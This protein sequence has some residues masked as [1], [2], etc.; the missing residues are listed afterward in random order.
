MSPLSKLRSLLV[1]YELDAYLIT[2]C[3][4]FSSYKEAPLQLLM[5]FSG[6]NGFAIIT[7]QIALLC[8]DGRYLLQAKHELNP[9][10]SIFDLYSPTLPEDIQNAI[11]SQST[12]SMCTIGYNPKLVTQDFLQNT[13]ITR[14]ATANIMWKPIKENLLEIIQGKEKHVIKQKAEHFLLKYAGKTTKQK[15]SE[16]LKNL[17]INA[18]YLLLT[19]HASVCWLMNIRGRDAEYTP[20][21]CAYALIAK[22]TATIEVF[23]RDVDTISELFF[24][25]QIAVSFHSLSTLNE[26]FSLISKTHKIQL[27]PITTPAWYVQN[28][29]LPPLIKPDPCELL[30]ACK[31]ESEIRGM[32]QASLYDSIAICKFIAWLLDSVRNNTFVDE[33]TAEKQILYFR[34]KQPEFVSPSFRT[35]SAFKENA[36]IIHYNANAFSNKVISG[37]KQPNN[38]LYLI[39]SG[40]QYIYGTT[41]V[42]RT[43]SIGT[44]FTQEER[45]NFTLVLKGHIHL[46]NAKFPAATTGM[47]LDSL[48]RYY[49]WQY[50]LDYKHGTGHGVGHFLSVHE[51][52]HSISHCTKGGTAPLVHNMIVSIEPGYYK[53]EAYGIRIENLYAVQQSHFANFMGFEPLS[54]VPIDLKL[55]DFEILNDSE[56][57]WLK[58]YHKKVEEKIFPFL[59]DIEKGDLALLMQGVS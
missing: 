15:L 37:T 13:L 29:L 3:E 23:C 36:A 1:K 42:T 59:S 54:L 2:S 43:I 28:T 56:I 45:Q 11:L 22:H 12:D 41:D 6:S 48:A 30:R 58:K 44:T 34:Q 16:L 32:Y 14:L 20:T 47:Q 51:G 33:L 8:T 27:D 21:I 18:D 40:G 19:S 57:T 46:A 55:V 31:N 24:D 38:G 4:E 10:H 25:P 39:D 5:G 35:I 26:K 17:D 53:E 50:G 49:L 7:Q 9:S 52:P